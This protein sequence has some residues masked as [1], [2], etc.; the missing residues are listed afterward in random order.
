[1]KNRLSTF[2]RSFY[3]FCMAAFIFQA[4]P[5][6][7][8]DKHSPEMLALDAMLVNPTHISVQ[9]DHLRWSNPATWVGG[10]VPGDGSTVL[11]PSG[12]SVQFDGDTAR[13]SWIRVQGHLGALN[14][15]EMTIRVETLVV[16]SSGELHLGDER[17]RISS[18]ITF[19][20]LDSGPIDR[21]WD[22][23]LLSRGLV[24]MGHVELFGAEV[25]PYA[26][27]EGA[28]A[29]DRVISLNAP[30][31]GWAPGNR[32]VIPGV[33]PGLRDD[34]E[35][36][37]ESVRADGRQVTLTS[38]LLYS[39]PSAPDRPMPVANLSRK[40]T[41][42]SENTSSPAVRGHF[43]TMHHTEVSYVAFQGLGRTDK[44]KA[45]TDFPDPGNPR[46]RYAFHVHQIGIRKGVDPA[47]TVAGAVVENSP[48]WG[49]VNHSSQVEFVDSIAYNVVGSGFTAEAGDEIGAFRRSL[50]IRMIG[51]GKSIP[52]PS[53]DR[54]IADFAFSGHG[55]WAQGG[56]IE[57]EDCIATGTQGGA[58]VFMGNGFRLP[59]ATTYTVFPVANLKDPS[60]IPAGRGTKTLVSPEQ[61]PPVFRRNVA[62]G[63]HLGLVIWAMGGN[64]TPRSHVP[65]LGIFEDSYIEADV[66]VVLLGYSSWQVLR[67]LTLRGQ[68]KWDQVGVSHT[69]VNTGCIYENLDIRGFS[70]GILAPTNYESRISGNTIQALTGVFLRNTYQAS[71]RTIIIK[72]NQFLDVP[73]EA[74]AMASASTYGYPGAPFRRF[75]QKQQKDV[76]AVFD[77]S[78]TSLYSPK[79]PL[80]WWT[81]AFASPNRSDNPNDK[82]HVNG[83][84]L[85]LTEADP[86]LV[87]TPLVSLPPEVRI[88][89]DGTPRTIRDLQT[90]L[91]L[92][93]GNAILPADA[94]PSDK[95]VQGLLS[96][97]DR[98]LLPNLTVNK[99]R[100]FF[101]ITQ[102]CSGFMLKVKDANHTLREFG[103]FGL[104]PN[105]W[106][107]PVVMIDG[108]RRGVP[109]YC[110]ATGTTAPSSW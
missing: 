99:D 73:P 55:F 12:S 22:T 71:G 20:F 106:S 11:I 91:G 104:R 24:S 35:A 26:F 48:G 68:G 8:H 77:M 6:Q 42:K 63:V 25:T 15:V 2:V 41:F 76:T 90:E 38:P 23:R 60:W 10:K 43:M 21:A 40:I 89:P 14:L 32:L 39:H 98:I 109:V 53:D 79:M 59:G 61:V 19:T 87:T 5:S 67:G 86:N 100:K 83:K 58:F 74:L 56:G 47:L 9:G 1:M 50:A 29:G 30:V 85:Y 101:Q 4:V 62:F 84:H 44:L 102:Q 75:Q 36:V 28:K 46:G 52:N 45:L 13:L 37:I 108:Y 51:D 103:P 31:E 97:G 66:N 54:R 107:F 69:G 96:D 64:G 82:M 88:R 93:L 34:D 78:G 27:T 17:N 80:G 18:Q 95:R 70:I 49:F 16:D 94:A 105:A 72:D 33:S 92:Y 57:M 3:L 7:A 65:G 110:D 81:Q